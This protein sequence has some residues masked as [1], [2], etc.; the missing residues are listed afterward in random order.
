MPDNIVIEVNKDTI[1][2]N[3]I[4]VCDEILESVIF[5][6]PE[7][8]R[9]YFQSVLFWFAEFDN[10]KREVYEIPQARKWFQKIDKMYPYFLYFVMPEQYYLYISSQK[11]ADNIG[12]TVEAVTHYVAVSETPIREFCA[13]IGDDFETVTTKMGVAIREMVRGR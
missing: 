13:R 6:T 2:G 7:S 4:S 1:E 8:A 12:L 10:D 9:Q 11:W 5:K 3:D